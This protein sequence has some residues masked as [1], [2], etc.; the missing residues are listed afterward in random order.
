MLRTGVTNSKCSVSG[1]KQEKAHSPC[2]IVGIQVSIRCL[3]NVSMYC[4][5]TSK[6]SL[7]ANSVKL[8][9]RWAPGILF[10]RQLSCRCTL[11]AEGARET[12]QGE[13]FPGSSQQAQARALLQHQALGERS[14]QQRPLPVASEPRA[15]TETTRWEGLSPAH[16]RADQ[17]MV[18]ALR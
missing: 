12:S 18:V 14:S 13:G 7:L 16:W 3:W 4:P 9:L 2:P 11:S 8:K 17:V 10:L 1:N 15:S 6:S 5:S